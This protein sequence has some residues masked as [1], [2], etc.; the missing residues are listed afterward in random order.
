MAEG[1][2]TITEELEFAWGKKR[3]KGGKRKDVQFYESFTLEGVEYALNDAVC[4]QNAVAGDPHVGRLIKIWENR[5]GSRKVKVQWFFR[6]QDIRAFL[7]GVHFRPNE[8]FLACGDGKGFANVNPLETIVD[9][10]NVLHVRDT[11]NP[12]SNESDADFVFFRFF[13]V[14]QRKVVDQMDDKAAEA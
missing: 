2:S 4:L 13:D 7:C 6:P 5:D 1:E 8:L 11:G 14:V 9:K 10:C 3:G 12:H